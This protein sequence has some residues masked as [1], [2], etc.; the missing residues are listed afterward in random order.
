MRAEYVVRSSG[1]G[2]GKD[3]YAALCGW[4]AWIRN[5]WAKYSTYAHIEQHLDWNGLGSDIDSA[6]TSERLARWAHTARRSR[7][8]LLRD[9]VAESFRPLF[10]ADELEC[11]PLPSD[12]AKLFELL[13]LV[14]IARALAP[15]PEELRWV[16]AET[17]D[18]RVRVQGLTCHYQQ[19]LDRSRV[20]A[21]SD[22]FGPL[23]TAVDMFAVRVPR[24]VDLAFDF[25][26][27]RAGFDGLI[28]EAKSG[29]Q[30]Y[31]AAVAQLRTYAN[32]R[33]R[34]SGSRYVIWGIVERPD[35]AKTIESQLSRML[36]EADRH[37]D[38]WVFS[39]ADDIG[40][41]LQALFG[42]A[43]SNPL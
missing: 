41:V 12:P 20:L 10:E 5:E 18:N 36:P 17:T 42:D 37:Q 38:L 8:P 7:W 43:V 13:C 30:Q 11:I 28:V 29:A 2:L 26:A 39:G 22:Y 31:D 15:P 33:P 40:I 23:A 6:F 32:A 27:P 1:I 21:T 16:D 4:S 9:V 14:R 35:T 19:N 34:R 3:E 25:E 24:Y